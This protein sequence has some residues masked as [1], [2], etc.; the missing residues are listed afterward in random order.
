[1]ALVAHHLLIGAA[2]GAVTAAGTAAGTAGGA[3]RLAGV[4]RATPE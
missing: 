3:G 2:E 1:M 4:V